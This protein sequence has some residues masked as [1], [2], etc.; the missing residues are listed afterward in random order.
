MT[1]TE[2]NESDADIIDSGTCGSSL[3]WTLTNE[4]VLTVS[5]SGAMD[6][7]T[8]DAGAVDTPWWGEIQNIVR[9][10][11]ESGVTTIGDLALYGCDSLETVTILGD[12]GTIGDYAFYDCDSLETV[13]I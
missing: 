1:Y 4:G 5:G 8:Y 10:E 9:V 2:S 12:V 6:N 13:T 7:Y 3:T 11:I